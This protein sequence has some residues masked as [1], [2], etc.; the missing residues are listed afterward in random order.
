MQEYEAAKGALVPTPEVMDS[1]SDDFKNAIRIMDIGDSMIRPSDEKQFVLTHN[2]LLCGRT[3][4]SLDV[5]KEEAGIALA[6]H[7]LSMF[8]AAHVY[9]S[10]QQ[11]HLSDIRWPE[12]ER[13]IELHKGPLLANEIPTTPSEMFRR[14]EYEQ[15]LT[16]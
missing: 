6:N 4:S 2:P 3:A 15:A 1:L 16:P 11:L 10:L 9:N 7:H 8:A 12:M 13:I 5:K 14:I